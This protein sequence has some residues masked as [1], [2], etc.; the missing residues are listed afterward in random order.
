MPGKPET[1]RNTSALRG[2]LSRRQALSAGMAGPFAARGMGAFASRAFGFRLVEAD[3]PVATAFH[4][5]CGATQYHDQLVAEVRKLLQQKGER[6]E[7]PEQVDCPVCGCRVAM[8]QPDFPSTP[9]A[10][11]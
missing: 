4:D 11:R 8:A 2:A 10:G 3:A 5:A 6:A 7:L 1:F 9:T